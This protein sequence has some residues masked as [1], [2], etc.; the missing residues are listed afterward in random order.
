VFAS[1][2]T[3]G[4]SFTW[5]PERLMLPPT[6]SPFTAP[7]ET[8]IDR[9]RARTMPFTVELAML[10]PPE[11]STLKRTSSAVSPPVRTHFCRF[12]RCYGFSTKRR[13]TFKGRRLSHFQ[14]VEPA[15]D[16]PDVESQFSS[17]TAEAT[18]CFSSGRSVAFLASS[19]KPAASACAPDAARKIP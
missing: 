8:F 6:S 12:Y 14:H 11:P 15:P 4:G 9:L 7:P 2:T 3:G 1:G 13:T 5:Q 10:T 19:R 17:R 16:L 18:S